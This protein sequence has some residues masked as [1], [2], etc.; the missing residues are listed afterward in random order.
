MLSYQK[1]NSLKPLE[2]K[3]I[4][5]KCGT[6]N[7]LFFEVSPRIKGG[8][9]RFIGRKRYKKNKQITVSVMTFGKGTGRTTKVSD[10]NAE[11]MKIREWE[12]ETGRDP[13]EYGK[14]PNSGFETFQD[15]VD[16][17]LK[18]KKAEVTEGVLHEYRLK[19]ENNILTR[20]DPSIPLKKLE[21]NDDDAYGRREVM[22]IVREIQ[23]NCKGQG[24]DLANRCQKLMKWI[25]DEAVRCGWMSTKYKNPAQY[26]KGD[27]YPKGQSHYPAL[28]DKKNVKRMLKEVSLN[29]YNAHP[30]QVLM[31]KFTFMSC[32][33]TGAVARLR[34][35]MR[36]T[37]QGVRC[38]CIDG[39]TSGIK[40]K[41]GYSDHLPHYLV[42][43]KDLE[44][45]L[46]EA[47][48]Y[49]NGSEYVFT[50]IRQRYKEGKYPH[51]TPSTVNNYLKNLG[52][53]GEQTGHGVRTLAETLGQDE[54][55]FSS[56]IIQRCM[57]HL[58]GDKTRQAYDRSLK[59]RKRRE[60][61]NAWHKHL[62][63]NGLKI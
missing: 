27:P 29:R 4:I 25:F 3:P 45:I 37:H 22:R 58:L 33:R 31:T 35:D 17:Y 16:S 41:K 28:V 38:F 39:K 14:D 2:K 12:K 24:V 50:P 23:D 19:I 34:W 55:D 15:A 61:M 42:I 8:T 51:A 44:K 60:F 21:W 43:T 48:Q 18:R 46:K 9:K 47:K 56:E 62:K 1:M 49:S 57:G 32:L 20:I 11:W 63:D 26:Y 52:F 13:R 10:A 40:R 5:V 30:V 53:K 6:G 7:G 36:T 59:L 54:L